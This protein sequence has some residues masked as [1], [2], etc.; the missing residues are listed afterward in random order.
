M[1][2]A[3]LAPEHFLEQCWQK[4][5]LTGGNVRCLWVNVK[6]VLDHRYCRNINSFRLQKYIEKSYLP[7][8]Q[9]ACFRYISGPLYET[10]AITDGNAPLNSTISKTS[11][12]NG[13]AIS[14]P[15]FNWPLKFD[16]FSILTSGDWISI[17]VLHYIILNRPTSLVTEN[18]A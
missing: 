7:L 18:S 5:M 11:N 2:G 1:H 4:P 13:Q 6:C 15:Y 8:C 3:D 16:Q 12:L 17:N 9:I 14:N 10:G